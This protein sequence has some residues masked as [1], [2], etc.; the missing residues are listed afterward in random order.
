MIWSKNQNS[1]QKFDEIGIETQENEKQDNLKPVPHDSVG[2]TIGKNFSSPSKLQ[3]FDQLSA[4]DQIDKNSKIEQKTP[5]LPHENSPDQ[6]LEQN[7]SILKKIPEAQNIK[8]KKKKYTFH[9]RQR[10]RP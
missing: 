8:I 2:L 10:A 1:E 7:S 3:I 5:F 9:T 4:Y 6:I